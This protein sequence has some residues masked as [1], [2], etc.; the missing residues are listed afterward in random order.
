MSNLIDR[1][2]VLG[3]NVKISHFSVKLS[4]LSFEF[5]GVSFHNFYCYSAYIL[6]PFASEL[7][8]HSNYNNTKFTINL[9]MISWE[10]LY[11]FWNLVM[12]F[13]CLS[14]DLIMHFW[15]R[16]NFRNL[17][18]YLKFTL[19]HVTEICMTRKQSLLYFKSLT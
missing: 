4:Q 17:P 14:L 11:N 9:C 6:F 1:N 19:C 15:K 2:W 16:L 18:I 12:H 5:A 8:G 7:P 3:C 13:I 10:G